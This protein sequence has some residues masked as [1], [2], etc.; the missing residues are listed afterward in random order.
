MATLDAE[1]FGGGRSKSCGE[2]FAS[3]G[4]G[5]LQLAMTSLRSPPASGTESMASRSFGADLLRARSG[6][7]GADLVQLGGHCSAVLGKWWRL[8]AKRCGPARGAGLTCGIAGAVDGGLDANL[9]LGE[10]RVL[11]VVVWDPSS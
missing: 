1:P 6:P 7:H 9:F 10:R 2:T 3:P 8:A 4:A 5:R 11:V